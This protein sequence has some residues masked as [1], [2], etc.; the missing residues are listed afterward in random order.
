MV[1]GFGH[2]SHCFCIFVKLFE[3]VDM[4]CMSGGCEVGGK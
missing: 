1:F 2:K 4:H 3:N